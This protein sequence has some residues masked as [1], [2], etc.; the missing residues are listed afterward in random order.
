MSRAVAPNKPFLNGSGQ[1]NHI[2]QVY[3]R[4][5]CHGTT[6]DERSLVLQ[7]RSVRHGSLAPVYGLIASQCRTSDIEQHRL[8]VVGKEVV[9]ITELARNLCYWNG[10]F[11]VRQI[12]LQIFRPI[13]PLVT[14]LGI[15]RKSKSCV[16]ASLAGLLAV[17]R[18]V[19]HADL[20]LNAFHLRKTSLGECLP[21]GEGKHRHDC[22][23]SSF[24]PLLHAKFVD[25]QSSHQVAV[26]HDKRLMATAFLLVHLHDKLLVVRN[27]KLWQAEHRLL[28]FLASH[29]HHIVVG[30]DRKKHLFL[31]D[32]SF[33]HLLVHHL[34][35]DIFFGIF[36]VR[37]GFTVWQ[38]AM[39]APICS[40][41]HRIN[42]VTNNRQQL[43]VEGYSFYAVAE[44]STTKRPCSR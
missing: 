9:G 35:R 3:F 42:E 21:C 1:S 11:T 44:I 43:L 17:I 12:Y 13:R 4:F 6:I 41:I 10:S 29:T 22:N 39:P 36:K 7:G 20:H 8:A 16:I 24:H 25:C 28:R 34:E 30:T 31:N 18:S 15:T 37:R 19:S 27:G 14:T 2:R 5:Q 33:C 23:V 26:L 40:N 38:R 32:G